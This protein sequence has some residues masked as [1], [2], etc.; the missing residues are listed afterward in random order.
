MAELL[1]HDPHS[2]AYPC[3]LPPEDARQPQAAVARGLAL[4][5]VRAYPPKA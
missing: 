3:P 4:A 5:T 1:D 2:F